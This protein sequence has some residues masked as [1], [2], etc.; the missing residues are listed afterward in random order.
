MVH[1][2]IDETEVSDV[3]V[4]N[5]KAV[6]GDNRKFVAPQF[7]KVELGFQYW[8]DDGAQ[9]FTGGDMWLDDVVI[10]DSRIHCPAK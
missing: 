5:G 4:V 8:H 3:A 10:N 2:I 6:R 7:Q 9:F 1:F